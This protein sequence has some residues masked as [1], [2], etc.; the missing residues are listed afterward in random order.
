MYSIAS[1]TVT[2]SVNITVMNGLSLAIHFMQTFDLNL[3]H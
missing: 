2:V 1:S 3:K